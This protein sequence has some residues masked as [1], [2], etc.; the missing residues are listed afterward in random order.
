MRS[1]S[2]CNKRIQRSRSRLMLCVYQEI[3]MYKL[4]LGYYLPAF[5]LNQSEYRL[6]NFGIMW[7]R[8]FVFYRVIIWYASCVIS[9]WCCIESCAAIGS[10]AILDRVSL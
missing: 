5:K 1:T 6:K 4:T 3:I 7:N 8:R 9:G 10:C 2:T